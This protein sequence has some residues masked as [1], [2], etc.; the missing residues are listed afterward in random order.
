MIKEGN[1]KPLAVSSIAKIRER[2]LSRLRER[3]GEMLN[4]AKAEG[5]VR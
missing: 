3:M 1:Y 5:E 2:A 4:P